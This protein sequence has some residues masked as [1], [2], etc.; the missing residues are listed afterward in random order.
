MIAA[1]LT[2]YIA[3]PRLRLAIR[4]PGP[5]VAYI[6]AMQQFLEAGPVPLGRIH[7]QQMET[8]ITKLSNQRT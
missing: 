6:D 4:P 8:V 5:S 2:I 7:S 1:W 3:T